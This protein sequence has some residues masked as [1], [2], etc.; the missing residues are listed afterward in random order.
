MEGI[1]SVEGSALGES[2]GGRFLLGVGGEGL[3]EAGAIT[4]LAEVAGGIVGV[5]GSEVILP[6]IAIGMIG[7][8]IWDLFD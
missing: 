7:K 1:G 8:A 5:V 3:A 6:A 2:L 4:G